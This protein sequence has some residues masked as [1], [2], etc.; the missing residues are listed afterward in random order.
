MTM[1][2]P[3]PS[4]VPRPSDAE[5]AETGIIIVDHGSR[6]AESNEMLEDFV[7][8]FRKTMRYAIVEPAH[9]E[10]AEPSIATAF[11][12][13]VERGAKRV[14][15]SPYF[16]APGRHWNKDIP[17]L[18]AEAGKAHPDVP[19]MVAAPIGLHPLMCELIASRIDYCLSHVAGKVDE[20]DV[21]RGT[22][23]CQMRSES[24]APVN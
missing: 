23:R 14:V 1:H 5:L 24:P 7:A 12:R 20:C 16:L 11:D 3:A 2:S 6:R 4:D 21:C 18:T 9:M 15:V 13:C 10:L 8:M 19:H 17:H 22:G